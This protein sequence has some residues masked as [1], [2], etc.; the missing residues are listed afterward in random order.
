MQNLVNCNFYKAW[1]CNGP[2]TNELVSARSP[3][4]L[5]SFKCTQARVD[6]LR[7]QKAEDKKQKEEE[8]KQKEEEKYKAKVER[9]RRIVEAVR[10]GG[11]ALKSMVFKGHKAE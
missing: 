3:G 9:A 2:G 10:R 8:K 11:R 6:R 1:S 4:H 5:R 7:A